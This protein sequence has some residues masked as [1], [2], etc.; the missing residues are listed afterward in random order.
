MDTDRN[1]IIA[2]M[3]SLRKLNRTLETAMLR[4]GKS[5]DT[6]S[7]RKTFN[8]DLEK[9]IQLTISLKTA[10][11][12]I[13]AMS[14]HNEDKLMGPAEEQ[15]NK[16]TKLK[17]E[18]DEKLATHQPIN[19]ETSGN[20]INPFNDGAPDAYGGGA[21]GNGGAAGDYIPPSQMQQQDQLEHELVPLDPSLAKDLDD[22]QTRHDGVL[23]VF[24]LR[25]EKYKI[26]IIIFVRVMYKNEWM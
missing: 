2:D 11:S 24:Y 22:I 23:K 16:F 17:A 20:G 18:I 25:N 19:D 9:G 4:I 5:N 3:K 15:S 26:C 12:R 10:G 21:Y 13:R 6:T 8:Y 14:M 7:W 1:K